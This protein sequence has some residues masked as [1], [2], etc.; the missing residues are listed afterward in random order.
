MYLSLA[1]A[2]F[3]TTHEWGSLCPG[4]VITS[5]YRYAE[6]TCP[7]VR[8]VDPSERSLGIARRPP[9]KIGKRVDA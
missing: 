9:R 4:P 5:S 1:T 3:H 6:L 2:T 7:Q 8:T